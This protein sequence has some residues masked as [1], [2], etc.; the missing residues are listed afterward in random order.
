MRGAVEVLGDAPFDREGVDG[1]EHTDGGGGGPERERL[2][3]KD[4]TADGGTD[5]EADLPRRARER[6]VAAE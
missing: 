3:L 4:E 1:C 5:E 2:V 6:H